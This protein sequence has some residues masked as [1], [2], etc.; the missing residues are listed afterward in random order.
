M[1]TIATRSDSTPLS[2][3]HTGKSVV[4]LQGVPS[5]TGVGY[6]GSNGSTRTTSLTICRSIGGWTTAD[7][8]REGTGTTFLV[9]TM[10]AHAIQCKLKGVQVF[11]YT[12]M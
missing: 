11:T 1:L 7:G 10:Q 12:I 8:Y 4:S 6:C 2:I 3:G 9:A 5:V